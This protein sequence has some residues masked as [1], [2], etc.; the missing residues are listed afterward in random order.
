MNI[1]IIEDEPQTANI[2]KSIIFDQQPQSQIL[3]VLDS[4]ESTTNFLT[5]KTVLPDLIFM[6]I[7]LADGLCFEIFKQVEVKCPIIFCTAYDQ[8]ALQ[9]FKT[10]GIYY[11]LKPVREEDVAKAFSKIKTLK[12][13]FKPETDV[14]ELVKNAITQKKTFRKSILVQYRESYIPLLM[15]DIAIFHLVDEILYA[16]TFDQQKYAIFKPIS[17]IEDEVN[18]ETFFRISR[19]TLVNRKAVKEIQPYFNR[20][21]CV[22]TSIK[23]PETLV[24]SRLKVPEFM[25]WMEQL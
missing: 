21:V 11:L 12:S 7:Q 6:D 8:Y 19:Q 16:Y 3:A 14:L 10:N 15:D 2:L 25:K 13:T 23:L 22:K 5:G 9:A 20:K 4:I 1:L 24:V 17:E 18:S